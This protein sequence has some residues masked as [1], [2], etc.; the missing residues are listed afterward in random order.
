MKQT[1]TTNTPVVETI[2]VPDT[3]ANLT[4]H[5][6]TR[7]QIVARALSIGVTLPAITSALA[8]T[9]AAQEATPAEDERDWCAEVQ[10]AATP[11]AGAEATPT[12]SNCVAIESYDIYFEP[13]LVT[14]PADTAVTIA[15]PNEG[16]TLHNFSLDEKG[17]PDLPIDPIDIDIDPGAVESTTVTLPAGTYYFYC[18]IPGHEAAGMYGYL[19]V[20]ADA[21]ISTETATVTPPA[22]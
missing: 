15:L 7:R 1:K 4:S 2:A 16:E 12:P 11:T 13:N 17:N 10:D 8:R 18:D 19:Q 6:R 9:A 5:R 21:E 14:I 3:S 20:E 22:G